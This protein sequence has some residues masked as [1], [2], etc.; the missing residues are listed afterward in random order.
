[1]NSFDKWLV[2]TTAGQTN[3]E[4]MQRDLRN[5]KTTLYDVMQTAYKFGVSEGREQA[6]ERD[7]EV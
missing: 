3:L 5:G 1:M 6:T 2:D 7:Y 4:A